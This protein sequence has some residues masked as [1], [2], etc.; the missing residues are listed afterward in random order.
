MRTQPN[1][2]QRARAAKSVNEAFEEFINEAVTVT[3]TGDTVEEVTRTIRLLK[4]DEE[5]MAEEEI[6]TMSDSGAYN[7][8]TLGHGMIKEDLRN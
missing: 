8:L 2:H 1:R 7:L 4:T 3:I 6:N 5:K